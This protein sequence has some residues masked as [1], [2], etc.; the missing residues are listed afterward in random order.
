VEDKQMVVEKAAREKAALGQPA[1]EQTTPEQKILEQGIVATEH[2]DA[3]N[4][5]QG[6]SRRRRKIVAP[7]P[8]LWLLCVFAKGSS[9]VGA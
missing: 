7:A 4:Q 8:G 5:K 6:A 9:S 3:G 2:E 1:L